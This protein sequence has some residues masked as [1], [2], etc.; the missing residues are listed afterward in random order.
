MKGAAFEPLRVGQMTLRNRIVR[1]AHGVLLPWSDDG[2]GQIDYHVAR[3][4][5]GTAMAVIGI[6]GVHPTNPTV[7]PTHE[8][9]VVPGLRSIANAVHEHGMF[10]VQQIWHGGAVKPNAMG[11]SPWSPSGVPNQTTG[12]IPVAMTKPMIDEMVAAFASAARRVRESGADGVEIH[13]ANGYLIT[14]FLSRASNFRQ[15]EYGGTPEN[16]I[17]FVNEILDAVRAQVGHDFTVGLRLTSNEFVEE[18]L[19]PEETAT[20][21]HALEHKIDYLNVSMGGY[22]RPDVISAP[23]DMPM[24]YQLDT[25]QI[26]TKAVSVPTIVT[27]RIMTMDEAN[28]IVGS[29]ISDLVS[30]VRGQIADPEIVKK[31][32]EDRTEQIRPCIGTLACVGTTLTGY[33]GCAVNPSAGHESERPPAETVPTATPRK[34]LVVGGGPA[35]MEAART[36]ALRGHDVSLYELRKEMGGQ[37][38]V[39]SRAPF[40]S[41]FKAIT[42]WQADEL[43]RIGVRVRLNSPVDPDVVSAELPDVLV[44][45]TGSEPNSRGV[46]LARPAT[47]LPGFGLEHVYNSRDLFG[48]GRAVVP[49][50]KALVFDDAGEYEALAVADELVSR[51][52][53]VVFATQFDGMGERIHAR[54]NTIAPT[55]RRLRAPKVQLVPRAHV[56]E[57]RTG[58]VVLRSGDEDFSIVVDSVFFVGLTE[59]N[60]DLLEYLDDFG[61]EVHTVGDAAGQHTLLRAIHDGDAVGRAI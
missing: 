57:I 8:D 2:G 60:R 49:G 24:G 31:S 17:R 11:G 3:A 20:I 59:P 36:A 61:G 5:G 10:L 51:G 43:T 18:G 14:Q 25:N 54:N 28:R 40:R 12:V 55:L 22:W 58:E 56:R 9:R 15:D 53:D 50:A 33:F 19:T 42:M 32:A 37:A 27:G 38:N 29:G 26:V 35:G 44:V 6:G 21:G 41:D 45:A 30:M 23:M 13:G 46:Q 48:Y 39:A 52:V 47:P 16:R 7:I 1:T 34:V 4:K